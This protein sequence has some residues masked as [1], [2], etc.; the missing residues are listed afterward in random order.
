M[1]FQQRLPRYHSADF[2]FIVSIKVGHGW[3]STARGIR[4]KLHLCKERQHILSSFHDSKFRRLPSPATRHQSNMLKNN[5]SRTRRVSDLKAV[6]VEPTKTVFER[7]K[8]C[9]R[10][11]G[12]VS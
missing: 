8:K 11:K 2:F 3:R 5:S 10:P 7:E 12:Y 9:R 6:A 1:S 4:K